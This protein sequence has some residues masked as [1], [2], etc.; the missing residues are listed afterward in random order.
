MSSELKIDYLDY[1]FTATLATRET[2]RVAVVDWQLD[3][4]GRG[5]TFA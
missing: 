1:R 5:K 3:S 4:V 2:G